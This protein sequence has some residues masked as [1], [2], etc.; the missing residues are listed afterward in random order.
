MLC[1]IGLFFAANKRQLDIRSLGPIDYKQ[2]NNK[3]TGT[4]LVLSCMK[5]AY[6]D[7]CLAA[8]SAIVW[9]NALIMGSYNSSGGPGGVP[10]SKPFL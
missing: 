9:S 7:S 4:L 2:L 10:M 6:S 3:P 5:A 1:C 8:I